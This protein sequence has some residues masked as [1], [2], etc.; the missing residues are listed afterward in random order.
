MRVDDDLTG[1]PLVLKLSP[2]YQ[3]TRPSRGATTTGRTSGTSV[4]P[5]LADRYFHSNTWSTGRWPGGFST[6][7]CIDMRL[8]R[9]VRLT[10]RE[11]EILVAL[12]EIKA[13]TGSHSSSLSALERPHPRPDRQGRCVLPLGPLR[14][15]PFDRAAAGGVD[16]DRRD[17]EGARV[18]PLAEHRCRATAPADAR[19][20]EATGLRLQRSGRSDPGR[21]PSFA[22]RW[23]GVNL[24]TFSPYYEDLRP[25]QQVFYYRLSCEDDFALD[26]DD[27]R[28]WVMPHEPR[29][30]LS[31]QPKQF[32]RRL[33]PD[34]ADA[35]AARRELRRLR[36]GG[37]GATP[38]PRW[39][40]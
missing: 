4:G 15:R 10:G 21:Y 1:T 31:D 13:G 16:R 35:V 40:T 5:Y 28:E 36:L 2:M 11:Q 19:S 6:R 22:G 24:P 3:R 9:A 20:G 32:E 39:T 30:A 34:R 37:R 8:Q 27:L 7:G 18:I 12:S 14:R 33:R 29:H 26:V 38:R 25:D 17:A 23:I